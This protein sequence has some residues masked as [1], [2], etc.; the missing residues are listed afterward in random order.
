MSS[1]VSAVGAMLFPLA[2]NWIWL[3]CLSIVHG[4]GDGFVATGMILA[5][6]NTLTLKQKAQGYGFFQL[7]VCAA[8]LCG[9]VI[10]GKSPR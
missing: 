4:L 7:C 6:L 1:A 2:T 9:P 8:A 5:T 3:L 10:G